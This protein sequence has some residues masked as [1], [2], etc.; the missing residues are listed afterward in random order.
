MVLT[1]DLHLRSFCKQCISVN[2]EGLENVKRFEQLT[3]NQK[4]FV[5]HLNLYNYLLKI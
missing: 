1:Q 4:A 3:E 5:L 2:L